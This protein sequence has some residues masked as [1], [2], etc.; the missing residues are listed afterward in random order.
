MAEWHL[1]QIDS[2]L[3][4]CLIIL[5]IIHVLLLLN[6]RGEAVAEKCVYKVKPA[7]IELTIVKEAFGK[8]GDLE[9]L[10]RAGIH[11]CTYISYTCTKFHI[12]FCECLSFTAIHGP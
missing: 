11:Q 8:W 9:A 2:H 3:K 7:F 5:I 4:Y 12:M 1:C 6:Y 10:K